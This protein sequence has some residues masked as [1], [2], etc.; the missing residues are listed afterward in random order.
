MIRN[1]IFGKTRSLLYFAQYDP[2]D[3][4]VEIEFSIENVTK[5]GVFARLYRYYTRGQIHQLAAD[6][7]HVFQIKD[8]QYINKNSQFL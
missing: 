7:Y 5:D 3:N 1:L 6:Q 2:Y 8:Y 4:L